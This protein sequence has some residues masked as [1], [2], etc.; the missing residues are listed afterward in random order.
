MTATGAGKVS[1]V[2]FMAGLA[3]SSGMDAWAQSSGRL[4]SLDRLMD[5]AVA[6]GQPPGAVVLAGQGDRTV[7]LAAY[8]IRALTPAREP[9]STDTVFDLASLTKVVATT[10]AVMKLVEEGRLRLVDP[11][12]THVPGF[13]RHG[14]GR[15]TIAH[16]LAHVSGLRP[17]VDLDD[18]WRGTGIALDLARDEVPV[19][20]PGERLI[21]SDINFFVLGEVVRAVSGEPLDV[22]TRRVI[23]EPL[24]MHD[25]GFRPEPSLHSRV[26]PTERCLEMDA[27]PCRR[28]DAEPLRAVVHDPT[29][30]RMGGVAGHAGLFSTAADLARFARM[31]LN[32]GTLDGVRVLSPATVARMTRRA[33]PAHLPARSLG[34]DL[35]SP[36]SSNRGELFPPG[37][38]GH[39]GFT[40]TSIWIDPASQGYVIFLSSRLYPDGVGDVTPLRARVA[41]LAAAAIVDADA[42]ARVTSAA[43]MPFMMPAASMPSPAPAAPVLAGVDV[44][45]RDGFAPLQGKRVGLLTNHT[46]RD[47]SGRSTIDVLHQAPGVTLTALFSPEHG[48]RGTEDEENVASETDARTGL[49]VHSL[50][51]DARRPTTEML[52]DLDVMVVDIQDVGARFYTYHATMGYVMEEAARAGLPVVV[53]DR[54]NPINGWQIEGPLQDEGAS[55]MVAYHPM[56]VRHGM[57]MGELAR[58]F[59]EERGIGASLSVVPAEHWIRDAWFD[60][61]GLMWVNPSPNMR[62]LNQATLY[63]GIGAIEFSNIS[64]GRGTDQPFEQLGAP[65]IDGPRLAEELNARRLPGIRFYPVMFTPSGS[66]YAGEVCQGVFMVV[67]DRTALS[68]V[69]VGL[70]VAGALGR[71]HGDRYRIENT[72]LLLGS[73]ESLERVTRGEDPADVAASWVAAESRWRQ[74]RAKYLLYR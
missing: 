62:N 20:P 44:L 33:T 47:R 38:F 16:L 55:G 65:W 24:G 39:T 67:T 68:P 6:A 15:I 5:A 71:L 57:T 13:E 42:L 11:V 51:G 56:P 60:Q 29:A 50:Y 31:L 18:P 69:R 61:T 52:R 64:V 48:I 2:L 27:W 46:G 37:S 63:P 53:L 28:P 41:T 72:A 49:P 25:T 9:M 74:R 35:D 21:Y 23:F 22:Y 3:L 45:A 4:A 36:S 17:D 19:A 12:A 59:N 26:A 40:G 1:W 7:H 58:L 30:R 8:G 34:W 32:G 43:S 14:K 10:T 54:P 70:E 73:R 66:K